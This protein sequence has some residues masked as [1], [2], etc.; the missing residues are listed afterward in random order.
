MQLINIAST[1]D[2]R[3]VQPSQTAKW[4]AFPCSRFARSGHPEQVPIFLANQ[5]WFALTDPIPLCPC[6][7]SLNCVSLSVKPGYIFSM[8][9]PMN[10]GMIISF[11]HLIYLSSF[12]IQQMADVQPPNPKSSFTIMPKIWVFWGNRTETAPFPRF[13]MNQPWLC[14]RHGGVSLSRFCC[15]IIIVVMHRPPPLK[16][17]KKARRSIRA[18]CGSGWWDLCSYLPPPPFPTKEKSPLRSERQVESWKFGD[19]FILCP[20]GF[21]GHWFR[22]EYFTHR[23]KYSAYSTR[24]FWHIWSVC[25]HTW[26][27][28]YWLNSQLD[29]IWLYAALITTHCFAHCHC[30]NMEKSLCFDICVSE[31]EDDMIFL[32]QTVKE[33]CTSILDKTMSVDQKFDLDLGESDVSE[34]DHDEPLNFAE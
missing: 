29:F 27:C 28:S 11:V 20:F 32:T 17:L 33:Q 10:Q 9:V 4:S 18:D 13:W 26:L 24:Y 3:C 6:V 30:V 34:S 25:S 23:I 19:C 15:V 2:D 7:P 14:F 8:P 16:P 12:S 1:A 31:D 5:T 21:M 22:K